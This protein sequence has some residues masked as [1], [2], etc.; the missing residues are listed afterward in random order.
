MG[1]IVHYYQHV[2]AAIVLI[3]SGEVRVGDTLHFKGHTTDFRERVDRIEFEH[4]PIEVARIGQTVG[5]HVRERVRE[6]DEVLKVV[7]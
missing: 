1:R 3:E 4:R 5:V 7:P 2:D 6:H